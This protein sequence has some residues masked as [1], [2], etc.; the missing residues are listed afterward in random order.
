LGFMMLGWVAEAVS[1]QPL[2]QFLTKRVFTPLAMHQT[3]YVPPAAWQGRCAATEYRASLGQHQWGA[4]HDRNA[5][6][7]GGVSGHAGLF[8]TIDDLSQWVRA[9]FWPSPGGVFTPS[10]IRTVL[11]P[12]ASDGSHTRAWG[13]II[14]GSD[15][16]ALAEQMSPAAVGHTGF[17]GTGIWFDPEGSWA[18]ILMTNRVH[19]GRQ[20]TAGPIATLRKGFLAAVA[21]GIDTMR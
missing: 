4:V 6:L 5:G 21:E 11:S 17:T 19:F 2:D 16:A 18:A 14:N 8:A 3:G 10:V 7:L 13:W 1:G 15:P 9:F 20:E 12:L